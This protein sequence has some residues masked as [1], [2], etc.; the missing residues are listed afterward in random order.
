M[1]QKQP[2]NLEIPEAVASPATAGLN[3]TIIIAAFVLGLSM[4]ALGLY[5][6]QPTWLFPVATEPEANVPVLV[7][8]EPEL[9]SCPNCVRHPLNG[10]L[11]APEDASGRPWAVMIDNFTEARPS[12]GLSQASLVF[13]APAEGGVT[14]YLAIFTPQDLGPEIGPVRS[15]RPYFLNW[16]KQLGATYVHVGGSPDALNEAKRLGGQDLNEFYN[17]SYFWRDK[18]RFA[19]HNVMTSKEKLTSYRAAHSDAEFVIIPYLF[20][21][22]VASTTKT[23]ARISVKY[24]EGYNTSWQYQPESNHYE[25]YLNN[26]LHQEKDQPAIWADNLIF[27]VAGFRVLDEKLRLEMVAATTGTA[28][29]CQDGQCSWGSWRQANNNVRPKYYTK[30]GN[31]F[32]FN[33]G[34]TWI[35]VVSNPE[36]LQY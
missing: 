34:K 3:K 27:H 32:I 2:K 17:G 24:G 11:V 12:A 6:F 26:N 7:V 14:R 29:L 13:E 22:G 10:L 28:L 5:M 25:R 19:P 31:E 9:V 18:Q 36:D 30:E 20:Q 23:Q 4:L 15:A 16:A 1:P 21:D 8:P 35:S 33:A